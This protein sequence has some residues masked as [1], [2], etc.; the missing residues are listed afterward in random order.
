MKLPYNNKLS[1]IKSLFI[2]NTT[3]SAYPRGKRGTG[4]AREHRCP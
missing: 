2:Y 3:L 1:C 4:A